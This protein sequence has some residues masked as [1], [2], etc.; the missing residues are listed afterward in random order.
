MI[1]FEVFFGC[2]REGTSDDSSADCPKVA[3]HQE[4]H[5][6]FTAEVVHEQAMAGADGKPPSHDGFPW[7][8]YIY[9]CF[10]K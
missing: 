7:D 5:Q 1:S 8:S 3:D 2:L 4:M 9:G 6:G 10:Q